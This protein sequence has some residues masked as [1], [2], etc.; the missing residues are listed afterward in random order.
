MSD[1]ADPGPWPPRWPAAVLPYGVVRTPAG[2]VVPATALDGDAVDLRALAGAGLLD[3]ALLDPRATFAPPTLDRLLAAGRDAWD[4]LRT[5]LQELAATPAR[6]APFRIALT[7]VRPQL[8][9]A[10]ADYVD[11]YSSRDHATHVGRIFR[12][13][14]AS[15]PPA[16]DHV[17]IGYHGRAGTVVVSGTDVVRPRGLHTAADG[18]VVDGPEPHLDVEVELGWVVGVPSAP[19]RRAATDVFADHVLGAVVVNDWSARGLQAFE[20]RPL[21]PFQAKAFA[22]SVSPWIVPLAALDAARVAPPTPPI[23]P[24]SHLAPAGDGYDV[25]LSLGLQ[26]ADGPTTVLTRP[27]AAGLRWTPAQQL[28]HL[29][30]SGAT[31]RTGDLYASGTISGPTPDA[32]GC[33]LERSWGWREPVPLDDGG[34][35]RDGL[36]D[37]DTVT[38]RAA[39]PGT[40]GGLLPLG[41]VTGRVV[42]ASG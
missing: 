21:G 24:A 31:L 25:H 27:R 5:R 29:T 2:E 13:D 8:A 28:A 16:W 39:F 11:F 7:E 9:W 23:P 34:D 17:P 10:V 26:P 18:T 19:G 20:Y 14:D 38:I 12:P 41:E 1:A 37:G 35:R 40:D 4:G 6:L 32:V 22:T 42:P 33:L 36:V 3:G 30:S 15:L